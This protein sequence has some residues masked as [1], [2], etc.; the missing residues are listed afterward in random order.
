[1]LLPIDKNYNIL[2]AILDPMEFTLDVKPLQ[3]KSASGTYPIYPDYPDK[4]HYSF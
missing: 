4:E 1:M 2:G 3:Q